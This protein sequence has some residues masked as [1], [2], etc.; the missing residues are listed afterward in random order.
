MSRTSTA[1]ARVSRVAM[2]SMHT[3]P[4]VPAGS[5][6]AGGM[7]VYLDGAARS[8]VQ[9]GIQVDTFT[10]EHAAGGRGI[11]DVL[12]GYR[13]HHLPAGPAGAS[14]DELPAQLGQFA[15][16]LRR[17]LGAAPFDVVHSHYWLSGMA[18]RGAALPWVHSMHTLARVKNASRAAGERPEP[19]PR[20][21]GEERV[22]A[23]CDLLIANTSAEAAELVAKYDADARRVR[24]VHP[25]VELGLFRPGNQAQE[26]RALGVAG[27][28]FVLL[29]VG[30]LQPLK[31][32]DLLLRAVAVL[33]EH[34]PRLRD[35]LQ[36]VVCGGPSGSAALAP[37]ALAALAASLGIG[38]MVRF[39]PPVD[40]A[41]LAR[42][43]RAADL[44]VV[45]SY[46]E[47]FGLV[48]IESQ[49]CGTPV[50]AARV[51]GLPTAVADGVGGVLVDGHDP[52]R[53][54][55]ALDDLISRPGRLA[56]LR[57]MAPLQAGLFSWD[58]TAEGLIDAYRTA[59]RLA[60]AD[61]AA[62]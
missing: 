13:V 62:G 3:S 35:V 42:W 44:T 41:E 9:R 48:A 2:V 14:K 55:Q 7:N 32:P 59:D 54:A 40:R 15:L 38:E 25:G 12:P 29:F 50:L 28:R 5:G 27:D 43:Y 36:V 31:A 51:G 30:R 58:A 8:L 10:R 49:A 22:I 39:V 19:A 61:A 34:H 21:V 47:S 53:W 4:L 11:V 16:R 20:I 6:D 57:A 60:P 52:R 26:R 46:S 1:P 33:V 45:P 37:E 18:V 24:V 23:D 56:A 17:E